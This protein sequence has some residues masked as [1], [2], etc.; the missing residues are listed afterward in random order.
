VLTASATASAQEDVAA[1]FKGSG[2][3]ARGI[4]ASLT[5]L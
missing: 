3:G 4:G 5:L 1:F 2:E